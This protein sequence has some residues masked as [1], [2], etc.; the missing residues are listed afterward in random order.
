M[1]ET[2]TCLQMEMRRKKEL[3]A[4]SRDQQIFY[5]SQ[6]ENNSHYDQNKRWWKMVYYQ[7]ILKLELKFLKRLDLNL[8]K[9]ED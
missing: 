7:F 6:A 9:K 2:Q 3:V 8:L 1:A 4:D 5:V